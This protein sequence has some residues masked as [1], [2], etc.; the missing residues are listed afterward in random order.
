[1]GECPPI[2]GTT[3]SPSRAA[4]ARTSTRLPAKAAD[5]LALA[6]DRDDYNEEQAGRDYW[7]TRNGYGVG[8]LDREQLNDSR[9]LWRECGSPRV[10]EPGWSEYQARKTP[11]IGERLSD[12]ARYSEVS[13]YRGDDGLIYLM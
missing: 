10:D 8:F 9:D 3:G 1:L 7:F 5:L 12:L 6:Y 11:T 4:I 2:S 13:P